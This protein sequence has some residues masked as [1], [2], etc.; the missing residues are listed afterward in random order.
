MYFGLTNILRLNLI[1]TAI[2][3]TRTN[4]KRL[5]NK[6]LINIYKDKSLIESVVQNTL[7]IK[8][9][10]KIIIATTRSKEDLIFKK[11][12]D[13][14]DIN[15]FYGSQNDLIDRT[16]QCSKKY[17]F[18]YFLRVCGDR[19]FFSYNYIN[20]AINNINK[21]NNNYD[22]ISNNKLNKKVD[23]GLTVEIISSNS[24]KKLNKKKLSY[25]DLENLTSYF[26]KN[27]NKFKFFYLKSPKSWFLNNKYTIDNKNDLLRM[28]YIISKIGYNKFNINKCI[29]IYKK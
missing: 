3:Y 14:Y 15:F 9:I 26:Y 19:P 11:V 12:L 16:I 20:S 18:N 25:Y 29:K 6:A 13:K 21:I 7:K 23:Q 8:S 4:S 17:N 10:N 27:E 24:L 1:N 5:K 28:K 22:I 2:I